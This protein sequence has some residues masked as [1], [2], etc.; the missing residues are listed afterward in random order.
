MVCS[1]RGHNGNYL[2]ANKK[3]KVS[4]SSSPELWDV[5]FNIPNQP[6]KVTLRN[7]NTGRYFTAEK[8]L[9]ITGSVS[10][11]RESPDFWESFY[12]EYGP[13]GYFH[14]KSHHGFYLSMKASGDVDCKATR[15]SE[16]ETFAL[17][18]Q[19]VV[20]ATPVSVSNVPVLTV[21]KPANQVFS[22]ELKGRKWKE[23]SRVLIKSK[24][25]GK[26]L[27][28]LRDGCV[29]GLGEEGHLAQ[30]EIVRTGPRTVKFRNVA[31]DSHWLRITPQGA[32]DGE[33]N[34]GP[35][36]EFEII[37]INKGVFSLKSVANPK[38]Y[39]AVFTNGSVVALNTCISGEAQFEITMFK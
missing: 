34:G 22:G 3:G 23:G 15:A 2:Y 33:G 20:V 19:H 25:S 29:N 24:G 21:V 35:L 8:I 31:D 17:I 13:P 7:I 10:C 11:N 39:I 12:F 30:F 14:L 32:V 18:G 38:L 5:R 9:G 36:T 16:W 4:Q 6:G 27:R 26:N 28:V 37:K 1:I